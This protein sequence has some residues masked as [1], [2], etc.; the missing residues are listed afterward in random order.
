MIARAVFT[1]WLGD[2]DARVC[3]G[4]E[5]GGTH[6]LRFCGAEPEIQRFTGSPRDHDDGWDI[7]LQPYGAA[8]IPGFSVRLVRY[9]QVVREGECAM[10]MQYGGTPSAYPLWARAV[11]DL[12]GASRPL[13]G[14]VL[15]KDDQSQYHARV[16]RPSTIGAAPAW[17]RA[18]WL[19]RD[20]CGKCKIPDTPQELSEACFF[21]SGDEG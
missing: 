7:D 13:D 20:E 9:T 8:G 19:G 11:R 3:L 14:I 2:L 6:D 15:I 12:R 18:S 1:F 16:I 17:L 5:S 4:L 21:V 10:P